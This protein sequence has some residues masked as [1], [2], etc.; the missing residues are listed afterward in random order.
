MRLKQREYVLDQYN[1]I[2]KE[3]IEKKLDSREVK[4]VVF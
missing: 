4:V 1:K 3:N 2:K